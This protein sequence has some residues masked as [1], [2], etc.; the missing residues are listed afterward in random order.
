MWIRAGKGT[1]CLRW[2]G[3]GHM[4]RECAT[5]KG[6]ISKG[7]GKGEPFGKGGKG[8]GWGKGEDR[9]CY[10]CGKKG[11]LSKDCWAAKGAKGESKGYGAKGYG[12]GQWGKGINEMLWEQ[13]AQVPPPSEPEIGIDGVWM[14]AAVEKVKLQATKVRNS[15][16]VLSTSEEEEDE[17]E[18]PELSIGGEDGPP[19]LTSSED[20]EPKKGKKD[21]GIVKKVQIRKSLKDR[22]KKVSLNDKPEIRY[23]VDGKDELNFEELSKE[24][25]EAIE[26]LKQHERIIREIEEREDKEE[27]EICAIG[28]E[29]TKVRI[30]VDSGA[31]ES[32]SPKD[33][34]EQFKMSPLKT[35]RRLINASGGRIPV[36]GERT[37]AL[38][39]EGD[40]LIGLPFTVCDV[41]K[42]LVS[43]KRI[44]EKGNIIQFGPNKKD[45]FIMNVKSKEKIYLIEENGQYMM[46]ATVETESPFPRRGE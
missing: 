25:D 2:M 28:A 14:I 8:K 34:F 32:V 13:P 42:P 46:E 12:K 37:V 29:K 27:K 36:H 21:I 17:E 15:F 31:A 1:Q 9:D 44:C 11:H 10:N 18:F 3:Y 6:A 45:S 24:I 26:E 23:I 30:T 35:S 22:S 38:K 5:V 41:K 7:G 16:E 40:R 20:E 43:V 33:W 39:T 19:G 4:A